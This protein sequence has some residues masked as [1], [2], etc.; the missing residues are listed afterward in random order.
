M[1]DQIFVDVYRGVMPTD[2]YENSV[3]MTR[4]ANS[5][6]AVMKSGGPITY[7]KGA[8]ILR[9]IEL[10]LGSQTFQKSLQRYLKNK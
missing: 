5:K 7:A 9:M 3:P 8:S 2:S 10:T 4:S 6:A 1:Q